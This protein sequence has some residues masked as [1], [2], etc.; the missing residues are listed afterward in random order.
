MFDAN[1]TYFTRIKHGLARQ[2]E[3][4]STTVVV[5]YKNIVIKYHP[6]LI[7]CRPHF[8]NKQKGSTLNAQYFYDTYHVIAWFF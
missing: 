3:I 8:S 7:S 1:L 4:P 2:F 6:L 5:E